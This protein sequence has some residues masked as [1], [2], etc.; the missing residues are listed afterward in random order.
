MLE[1]FYLT[2][3]LFCI[4]HSFNYNFKIYFAEPNRTESPQRVIEENKKDESIINTER[5]NIIIINNI[6]ENDDDYKP[7]VC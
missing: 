6:D 7:P 2:S 3:F 5:T 1:V 4:L